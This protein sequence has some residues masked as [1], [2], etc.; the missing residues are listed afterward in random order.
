MKLS[1]F[2]ISNTHTFHRKALLG[3]IDYINDNSSPSLAVEVVVGTRNIIRYIPQYFKC[4]TKCVLIFTG[5]GRL[6][7]NYGVLGKFLFFI[8]VQLFSKKKVM[9]FIVENLDDALYLRSITN[10]G[11]F[12][13]SGSGLDASGFRQLKNNAS[14]KIKLGYLSRFDKSKGS[15]EVLKIANELPDSCE[16][17]IAG[18]DVAGQKFSSLYS[19]AALTKSNVHYL[20]R[21]ISREEVSNFF[22]MIDVL[23]CPSRREGGCI[24]IQE[25]V[26]HLVPFITTNVPGCRQLAERFGCPAYELKNYANEVLKNYAALEKF[27]TGN[28]RKKL[29]P[30][31]HESVQEEYIK[32]FEE[33]Q[34]SHESVGR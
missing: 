29:Q 9:A 34:A 24:S 18:W 28:W 16:L 12:Q 10:I 14:H 13:T 22:N 2:D 32:I 8:I 21:L 20:E 19:K 33:I 4:N 30:F 7:T 15:L 1:L 23:L 3:A 17:Y 25:A 6:F 5:F 11:V 31:L 26:W 27:E